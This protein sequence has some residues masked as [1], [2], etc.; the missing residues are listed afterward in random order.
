[1]RLVLPLFQ[2]EIQSESVWIRVAA[3]FALLLCLM[4]VFLFPN[5]RY[6]NIY[7]SKYGH[8]PCD[9]RLKLSKS[10]LALLKTVSEQRAEA[11]PRQLVLYTKKTLF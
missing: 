4:D 7:T 11:R 9:Y 10:R 2:N 1:M 8:I 6:L 5:I 3:V